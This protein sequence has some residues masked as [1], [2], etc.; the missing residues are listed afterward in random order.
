ML[1]R[2]DV[3]DRL[4]GDTEENKDF[5]ESDDLEI[6]NEANNEVD[7]DKE[8]TSETEDKSSQNFEN[9][10]DGN[11]VKGRSAGFPEKTK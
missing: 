6:G 4:D 10:D 7:E 1:N 5:N 8:E 3:K 2:G 11:T 9:S